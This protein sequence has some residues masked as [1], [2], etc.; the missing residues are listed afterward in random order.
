MSN[1]IPSF[2][3]QV[4]GSGALDA[5]HLKIWGGEILTAFNRACVFADKHTVRN[6]KSGKSAQ[7]PATG[8]TTAKYHT[9]GTEIVG[10]PINHNERVIT[11]DDLLISDVFI[12]EIDEAKNHYDIRSEYTNQLGD[13]LAQAYDK[14]VA[15]VGVLAARASNP[16]TGLPGGAQVIDAGMLTDGNKLGKGLFAAAQLLDEKD[17]PSADRFAYLRPAQYYLAVQNKDLINKDFAALGSIASGTIDSVAGFKIVKTNNLPAANITAGPTKYR[18]DFSKTAFL[19]MNR[20]AVGTVKL[21]DLKIES[22][23]D[24]RRQGT[25]IVAKYAVG[26]DYL[27]PNCAVEGAT[28]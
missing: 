17:V 20:G 19:I 16:V 9:P 1:A 11:I 8:K 5:L 23:Y 6:I 14:N 28:T 7:F 26:H 22:G 25:L 12:A 24:L 4:N 18:G 13:A 3:G 2:T 15:Q 21:L 27:R 10:S